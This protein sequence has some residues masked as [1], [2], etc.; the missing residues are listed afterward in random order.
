RMWNIG[1]K[2]QNVPVFR[3]TL[4]DGSTFRATDDHLIML[5]DG[6]YRQ[7]KDLKSQDSLM[8]FHSK[9]L[10][11][12]KVRTKRRF[13]WGGASWQ[14]QYRAVW[15][16]FNDPAPDGYHIHHVD[17]DARN[18]SPENLRLL[19]MEDH[20]ALHG[21]RIKGDANPARRMMTDEWRRN[22][23][24]A[25]SGEKNGNYGHVYSEA[26]LALMRAAAANRWDKESEHQKTGASVK[27]GLAQAKANGVKIGA[28]RKERFERSCPVCREVFETPR[29]GQIFCSLACR[30][31]PMGL[32]MVG[33]KTW[34]KNRGRA[35]SPEHRAKLS[36]SVSLASNPEDKR[37]AAFEAHRNNVLRAAR[38]LLDHG[39]LPARQS[40]DENRDLAISLGAKKVPHAEVVGRFFGSD[41]DLREQAALYNHK[42]I[43]VE[44]DGHEDVYDGTVDY[45]HNFAILTS[46]DSSCMPGH[47]N[48][49]GTFIHNSEYMFLDD[50]ACNLASI[51]LMKFYDTEK[52]VFQIEA[53][54]HAVRLWTVVLEISVLMAQFPSKPIAQKTFDYRTLG[55]GYA[56]LGAL[57]MVQGIPYDSKKGRAISGALTAILTGDSYSACAE[58][59]RQIGPFPKF[60]ENKADMLRVIRNHRRAAYNSK[61]EDYEGLSILPMGIDA[62]ECPTDLMAAAR[63]SWDE[64]L[65]SG[66]K[67]GYRNAQATCIAPTGTIGLVM[68]CDTTGIEPDFALVKFK[69]LA[70]GGYF[71]I[72]NQSVPPALKRLGYAEKQIQEI[73]NYCRGAGTLRSAPEINHETLKAKG[74]NDEI[75]NKVEGQLFAAFD[76]TFVFNKWTLG[77]DFLKNL[78]ISEEMFNS[79][80]F[81]LL[82][83]LG[84]TDSQ[85]SKANDYCCGTMT[86]EGAP[87]LKPEHYPIFDCAT[88]CG[89]Y[90]TRFIRTDGHI[91]MMAAAQP[92]IS[93]AIS[94]TINMPHEATVADV[95]NAYF[96]SWGMCLKANALYRDGSKL[97][98]P[99]NSVAGELFEE[100]QAVAEEEG[101]RPA[102]PQILEKVIYRYLS[103]RRTLPGRRT[104]YTQKADVGGHK[105]Y[106]RTGE[107][108]DGT[109]GEVFLD[110]HKEGAAFRSLMNCF[111]IAVSIGFQ[112]GVPLEEF[113][114]A[115]TFTRF[116]PNGVVKGHDNIKMATS[117]IDYI[118]RELAMNYLGRYDLVHINPEDLRNTAVKKQETPYAEEE[119]VSVRKIPMSSPTDLG[120]GLQEMQL[121]APEVSAT[122]TLKTMIK[123]FDAT[124]VKLKTARLKGYEG[125]PCPEC[126]QMTLLRNGSCLKCDSCGATTGC[127]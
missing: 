8:P 55:L 57:L 53:Y 107:F 38:L 122:P 85:I 101:K 32:Q 40:W 9:I 23:S 19:K 117:V 62:S 31:S 25:V 71:K 24:A 50:T 11:P 112:Y 29:E 74:F 83:E 78:S 15:N 61:G 39:V 127:S 120:G 123:D 35:L 98:Q 116:E 22:I 16:Y 125:D 76:I 60:A 99:L 13:Y 108:E 114:E 26:S 1:V 43:S 109:L 2:R 105:V 113:V 69:K 87:H 49:S 37:R 4:D 124:A 42:V 86:I 82:K 106:L 14:P 18:D 79:P 56:N 97:S 77:E 44:F 95:Q 45:H 33:P 118:F 58:M 126:G 102:N 54:R 52:E 17:F 41:D 121:S 72:I 67:W 51:N 47:Q 64:A 115:F 81:N 59:A 27:A 96:K 104:G 12:A 88:K 93:G 100:I 111:A 28:P 6:S 20:M 68:D 66:E 89:K 34:E 91:E 94:K 7:V 65:S 103:K 73:V 119:V 21:D 3:V 90:G 70:G 48:F 46:A 5:R 30:Y 92:F 84:F 80:G 63:K 10:A 110:M 36:E 75:L